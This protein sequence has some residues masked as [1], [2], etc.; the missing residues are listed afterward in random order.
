[1]LCVLSECAQCPSPLTTCMF[2][3][4][5]ALKQATASLGASS[6]TTAVLGAALQQL[7]LP[8]RPC[9]ALHVSCMSYIA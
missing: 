8:V 1:M 7:V 3:T 6:A 9:R 5:D 2:N 4:Y